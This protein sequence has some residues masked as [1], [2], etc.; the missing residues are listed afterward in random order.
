MSSRRISS[1]RKEEERVTGK[2]VRAPPLFPLL[3]F[4]LVTAVQ[5]ITGLRISCQSHFDKSTHCPQKHSSSPKYQFRS[6]RQQDWGGGGRCGAQVDVSR[7]GNLPSSP[8]T[9]ASYVKR[10]ALLCFHSRTHLVLGRFCHP[11]NLGAACSLVARK[12]SRGGAFCFV[13]DSIRING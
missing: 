6:V 5:P 9:L 8:P 11:V 12:K 3:R 4:S 13:A 1:R 10:D 2:G 7:V